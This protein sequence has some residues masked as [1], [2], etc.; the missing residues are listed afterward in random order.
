MINH[1]ALILIS[2]VSV[3]PFLTVIATSFSSR[4]AVDLK[5]VTILPIDFTIDSWS[6]ILFRPDLWRAI[7]ITSGTTVIG[8]IFALLIT[9]LMAY[10]LAKTEFKIGK[11]VMLGVIITM[12][13]KSPMI[14][15]FLTVRNI[16]LYDS[17]LVLVIPHVLSA[18]NLVIMR[19]FFKQFPKELEESGMIDG[20]GMFK[21]LFKIV[22]PGSK[23]VLATLGLFYGVVIWNQYQHPLM[24]IQDQALYP[25]QMKIRQFVT[26][27]NT[28]IVTTGELPNYNER[29]LRAVVVLIAILPI[30]AIYPLLQKYFVKGAMLGSVKG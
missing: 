11:W 8:T 25:L 3:M 18:Y 17:P 4:A 26:D 20:C 16:G 24:F 14:P 13:F 27:S 10:P 6:Y 1:V 29:T 23:A 5:K 15:Y 28:L 19:S 12:V 21:T 30:V 22:L 7:W 2:I 9:S